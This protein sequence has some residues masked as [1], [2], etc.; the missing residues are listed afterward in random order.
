[1]TGVCRVGDI[2]V[3][4]CPNHPHSVNYT[5]VFVSGI[6]DVVADDSEVCIVGTVGMSTCGHPTIALSGSDVC[7]ADGLGLHR[8]GD[9]GA[10]FGPYTAILGADDVTSE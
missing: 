2:G 7:N 10:N 1:M 3:G 4:V 5:T 9:V 8:V 6:A